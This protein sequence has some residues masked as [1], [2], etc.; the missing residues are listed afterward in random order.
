LSLSRLKCNF[1]LLFVKFVKFSYYSNFLQFATFFRTQA[2]SGGSVQD[3]GFSEVYPGGVAEANCEAG[4]TF[5]EQSCWKK[6]AVEEKKGT[7][8]NFE[9]YRGFFS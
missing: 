1:V 7:R 9:K 4:W 8:M 6:F 3:T 5:F 2:S